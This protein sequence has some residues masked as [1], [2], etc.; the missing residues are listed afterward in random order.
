MDIRII[1]LHDNYDVFKNV[2]NNFRNLMLIGS[3]SA[4]ISVFMNKQ[5][6][7]QIG[8]ISLSL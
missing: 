4:L 6:N 2:V 3:F 8:M 7:F 5:Q 1:D